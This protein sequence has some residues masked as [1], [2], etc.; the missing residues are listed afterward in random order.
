MAQPTL[1]NYYGAALANAITA[2]A[3]AIASDLGMTAADA[4]DP[5]KLQTALM[6]KI[7]AWLL[8]DGTYNP[9]ISIQDFNGGVWDKVTDTT[10]RSG[11]VGYQSTWT[12][13]QTDANPANPNPANAI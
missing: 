4:I 6:V 13:W 5:D 7:R 9:G 8:A 2:N 10:N 12:L 11:Q 3:A 1:T